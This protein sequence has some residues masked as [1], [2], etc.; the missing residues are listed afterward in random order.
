MHICDTK[1]KGSLKKNR[2][3]MLL[4]AEYLIIY[5]KLSYHIYT[6]ILKCIYDFRTDK[7][8]CPDELLG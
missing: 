1:P 6:V 8:S 4:R 3:S 7:E 5:E 2:S